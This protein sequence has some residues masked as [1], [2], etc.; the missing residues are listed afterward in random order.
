MQINQKTFKLLAILSLLVMSPIGLVL[1]VFLQGETLSH[2]FFSS[3]FSWTTQVLIGTGYGIAGAA[4]ATSLL[5]IPFFAPVK[6]FFGETFKGIQLSIF[7]ILLISICVGI[8][9][10]LLFRAGIQPFLGIWLT[11][12]VFVMAHGIYLD[13]RKTPFFVVGLFMVLLSS[14]LGYLFE[15]V[16]ITAAIVAHAVYD[17]I[18][19][20]V[21][22]K[23]EDTL[24]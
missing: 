7:D 12:I 13:P 6:S 20:G 24:S 21:I 8:G 1:V 22:V 16:S 10:E 4:I 18:S 19:L 14:G 23:S 2:L 9:E 5:K 11:S 3:N 15:Y 17:A